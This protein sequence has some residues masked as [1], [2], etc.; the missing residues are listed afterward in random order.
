[1]ENSFLFF[2]F[3]IQK[4]YNPCINY[5]RIGNHDNAYIQIKTEIHYKI[6]YI[7]IKYLDIIKL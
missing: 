4:I 3:F 2:T 5:H 1:M 7:C 6:I